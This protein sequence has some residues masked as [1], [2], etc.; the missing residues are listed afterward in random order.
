MH[1]LVVA[2][3]LVAGF[4]AACAPA[5]GE[6]TTEPA[7]EITHARATVDFEQTPLEEADA[8]HEVV[9]NC[10]AMGL[11]VLEGASDENIIF[12][13]VSWCMALG[14]LA[15]G[16]TNDALTQVE[17]AFGADVEASSQALNALAGALARYE[18]DPASVSE[19]ELPAEPILHRAGNAVAR[20]DLD[21]EQDYLN[22]LARWFDVDVTRAD[23]TSDESTEVLSQWIREHT[24]GRIQ[25]T[26]IEPS[27]DLVL[28]LQDALLFAAAWAREFEQARLTMD[29]TNFDGSV[30]Q[31]LMI[32]DAGV[33]PY[34]YVDGWKSGQVPFTS[35]FTATFILPPVDT[36]VLTPEL[37]GRILEGMAPTDVSLQFP[38]FALE[39]SVDLLEHLDAWALDSLDDS[40]RTPLEGIEPDR[41]LH[42]QQAHQQAMI[43]VSETGTVAAA[44]T[45]IGI[46][47]SA[48]APPDTALHLVRPF[49]MLITHEATGTDIFQVGVRELESRTDGA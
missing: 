3:G 13:P 35:D 8:L 47:E 21:I 5:P 33:M 49:Y 6:P 37:R 14:M 16:A 17:A 41:G 2:L 42:V 31:P 30:V 39:T 18:G 25:E 48:Q 29:F 27:P 36:D 4:L 11:T 15:G 46:E 40:S 28:V 23:L 20:D 12:S 44:V 7:A 22:H 9:D 26:A 43:D 24:G 19:D 38:K 10:I 45:E 32:Q 34:S 1:R